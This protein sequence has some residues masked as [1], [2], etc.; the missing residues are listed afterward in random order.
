MRDSE[1]LYKISPT[2]KYALELLPG[3]EFLSKHSEFGTFLVLWGVSELLGPMYW[4]ASAEFLWPVFIMGAGT[5]VV[6]GV[7]KKAI[8]SEEMQ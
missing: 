1:G 6:I 4:W 8:L 2:G 3:Y 5:M 7:I